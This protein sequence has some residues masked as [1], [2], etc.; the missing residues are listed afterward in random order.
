MEKDYIYNVLLQRGYDERSAKLV[1]ED[2]I[3]LSKPLD[4]Y[5]LDWIH[6]ESDKKDFSANGFS[7]SQLQAERQMTYP[8]ALLTMDWLLKEPEEGENSLKRGIK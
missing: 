7:I 4:D 6:N 8:A 5:L 2:L 1:V 3:R